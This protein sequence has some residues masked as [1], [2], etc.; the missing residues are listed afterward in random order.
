MSASRRRFRPN[1]LHD[2]PSSV[3]FL[4]NVRATAQDSD[5]LLTTTSFPTLDAVGGG[6]EGSG[7]SFSW[8]AATR[9][10]AHPPLRRGPRPP[11]ETLDDAPA[12]RAMPSLSATA[13]LEAPASSSSNTSRSRGLRR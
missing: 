6:V 10:L 8:A 3:A 4:E 2:A 11:Y 12:K 9:R 1:G 7:H 5:N 13:R